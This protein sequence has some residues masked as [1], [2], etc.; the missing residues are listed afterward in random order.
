M[1]NFEDNFLTLPSDAFSIFL[2]TYE[3]GVI[4][5]SQDFWEDWMRNLIV[6]NTV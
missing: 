6:W 4:I 2:E 1:M 5:I 3:I